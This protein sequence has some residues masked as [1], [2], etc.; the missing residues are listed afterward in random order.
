GREGR[1]GRGDRGGRRP[2]DPWG[3][4]KAAGRSPDVTAV[5]VQEAACEI[6][7]EEAVTSGGPGPVGGTS[8]SG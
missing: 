7:C 4:R 2:R 6:T 1:R 8:R 3:G 5:A